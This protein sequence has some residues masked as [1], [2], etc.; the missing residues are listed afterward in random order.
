MLRDLTSTELPAQ[1]GQHTTQM[2]ILMRHMQNLKQAGVPVLEIV[3]EIVD[4]VET[5]SFYDSAGLQIPEELVG[6]WMGIHCL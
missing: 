2:Q 6:L 1:Q 3:T 4:D 5:F